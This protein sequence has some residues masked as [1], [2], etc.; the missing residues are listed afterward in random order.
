MYKGVSYILYTY[1][2]RHIF[3]RYVCLHACGMLNRHTAT[4]ARLHYSVSGHSVH[5]VGAEQDI[6]LCGRLSGCLVIS[7]SAR[8]SVQFGTA[9]S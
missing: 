2:L 6:T 7:G 4:A 3:V 5:Q 1:D 9:R 8:R